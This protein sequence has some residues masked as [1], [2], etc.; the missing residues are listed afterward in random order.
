MRIRD[1]VALVTGAS[2]GIGWATA[3]RLAGAGARV[4]VHGRDRERL[5][6]LADA[7]GGVPLAGELADPDQV[8]RLAAAALEV[9]GRVDVVV[10]SAGGGWAGPFDRMPAPEIGRL[11]AVNLAAPIGLTRALLP[12]MRA[13]GSGYLM[14]VTS[15]A[16][17]LGVA[18]EAV[19]AATKGGLDAFAE[20]LR[21]ELRGTGVGVGALAPGVVETRF[22]ER[23]G[24]PYGRGR[25]RPIPAERVADVL[26]R[27]I[28][29]ERDDRYVPGWLRLPVAV[30]ATAPGLYRR[31][32]GRFG[33]S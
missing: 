33:G 8:E 16:G 18:G 31:L 1:S 3:V 27:S 13:R 30:R 19:Y 2:S 23:R 15:I 12:G 9:A 6:A 11:V 24:Q 29:A 28:A 32:A 25:P 5:A 22:F 26:V 4:V 14:F 17:R 20:S 21:L 7:V 10:H